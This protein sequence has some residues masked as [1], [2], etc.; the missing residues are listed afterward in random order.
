ML[1]VVRDTK[2]LRYY[3]KTYDDQNIKML[4]MKKFDFNSKKIV[5]LHTLTKQKFE[6]V[7]EKLK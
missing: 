3:Y 1:T 4:D 7:S 6:D 2:N 5:K